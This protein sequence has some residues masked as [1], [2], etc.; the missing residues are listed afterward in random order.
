MAREKFS[1]LNFRYLGIQSKT[2]ATNLRSKYGQRRRMRVTQQSCI[3]R[4][5]R[6]AGGDPHFSLVSSSS[7][8]LKSYM[9]QNV[10]KAVHRSSVFMMNAI[11]K[12]ELNK[13]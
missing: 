5:N 11:N 2:K 7:E 4:V 8:A 13:Y 1:S 6:K 12:M 3:P 9:N 10:V